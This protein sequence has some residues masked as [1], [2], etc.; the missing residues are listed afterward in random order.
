MAKLLKDASGIYNLD[1]VGSIHPIPIKGDKNDQNKVTAVFTAIHTNGGQVH[2]TTIPWVA[3]SAI[4]SDYWNGGVPSAKAPPVAQ[5]AP[6]PPT[7]GEQLQQAQDQ[8]AG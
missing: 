6:P 8:F 3:A 4:A 2:Q 7:E 5:P 1:H